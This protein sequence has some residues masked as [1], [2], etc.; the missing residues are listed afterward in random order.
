MPAVSLNFPRRQTAENGSFSKTVRRPVWLAQMQ[1]RS[2][3]NE[4]I[5]STGKM[6]AK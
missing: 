6:S 1:I 2:F 3:H 4:I 5:D